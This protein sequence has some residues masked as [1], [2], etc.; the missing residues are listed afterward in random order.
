MLCEI[1]K[2]NAFVSLGR[3]LP[4]R[5][6]AGRQEAITLYGATSHFSNFMWLQMSNFLFTA[7]DNSSP[8]PESDLYFL[9]ALTR[10]MTG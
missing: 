3:R 9:Q 5:E 6:G 7:A 2:I 1:E 8:M 10:W 4:G